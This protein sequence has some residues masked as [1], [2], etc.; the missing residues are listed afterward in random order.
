MRGGPVNMKTR[1]GSGFLVPTPTATSVHQKSFAARDGRYCVLTYDKFG[2]AIGTVCVKFAAAR[3]WTRDSISSPHTLCIPVAAD[4][5]LAAI[6]RVGD[7]DRRR[8]LTLKGELRRVLEDQAARIS[9]LAG[10]TTRDRNQ[11]RATIDHRRSRAA[12]ARWFAPGGRLPPQT[13]S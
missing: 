1:G 9:I 8:A 10:N 2:G 12:F 11:S 13:P 7:A 6:D 3:I 5:V 4:L